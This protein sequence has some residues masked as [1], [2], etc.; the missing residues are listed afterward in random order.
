MVSESYTPEGSKHGITVRCGP[1]DL[2]EGRWGWGILQQQ[3]P[4]L[5][6]HGVDHMPFM[7]EGRVEGFCNKKNL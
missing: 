5:K 1:R 2:C 6:N 7:K 3:I 4:L